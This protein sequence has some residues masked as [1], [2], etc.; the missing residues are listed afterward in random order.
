MHSLNLALKSI[1]DPQEKSHQYTQ[2]KWV[3]DLV[4]HVYVKASKKKDKYCC[5]FDDPFK[6]LDPLLYRY[7][8]A[9]QVTVIVAIILITVILI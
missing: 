3:S 6:G 2:C 9:I 4:T 7:I 1:C 5:E 8:V